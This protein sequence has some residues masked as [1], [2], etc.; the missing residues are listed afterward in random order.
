MSVR[1]DW[2]DTTTGADR[3]DCEVLNMHHGLA[4][5]LSQTVLDQNLNS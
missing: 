1:F 2:D 5:L 4:F 3:F